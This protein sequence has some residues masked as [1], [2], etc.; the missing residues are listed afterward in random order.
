[1]PREHRT[2]RSMHSRDLEAPSNFLDFS[3]RVTSLSIHQ[4]S[5]LPRMRG[6]RSA[7]AAQPLVSIRIDPSACRAR[8]GTSNPELT[9]VS[10]AA[11]YIR[12]ICSTFDASLLGAIVFVVGTSDPTTS[13]DAS[14][15]HASPPPFTEET[16]R[17]T[18]GVARHVEHDGY[19]RPI[20]SPRDRPVEHVV[21][22]HHAAV[23]VDA[24]PQSGA[25]ADAGVTSR[26]R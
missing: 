1:M 12:L 18:V 7:E 24:H 9:S 13:S 14:S 19:A 16:E 25:A 4:S 23:S 10:G 11:T 26:T 17:E 8:H 21:E 20:R 15:T 3:F 6:T 22:R 2:A 5:D